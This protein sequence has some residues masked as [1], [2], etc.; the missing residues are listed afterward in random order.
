MKRTLFKLNRL[1][2]NKIGFKNLDI[3][4]I[5]L[6][7]LNRKRVKNLLELQYICLKM[8]FKINYPMDEEEKELLI[9]AINSYD[10]CALKLNEHVDRAREYIKE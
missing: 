8:I 10:D 4:L 2:A 7:W 1:L 3:I 6:R 5:R 9:K